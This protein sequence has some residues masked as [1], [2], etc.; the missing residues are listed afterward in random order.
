MINLELKK[1]GN[2]IINTVYQNMKSIYYEI[3]DYDC[4]YHHKEIKLEKE[5]SFIEIMYNH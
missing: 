1:K 3:P 2:S 5:K 4:F